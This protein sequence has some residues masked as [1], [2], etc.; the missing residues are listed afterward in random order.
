MGYSKRLEEIIKHNKDVSSLTKHY[1]DY[2]ILGAMHTVV[3]WTGDFHSCFYDS[4]SIQA[5]AIDFDY[6][7]I[8]VIDIDKKRIEMEVVCNHLE[9]HC[10]SYLFGVLNSINEKL[11]HGKCYVFG[12]KVV[13]SMSENYSGIT[14]YED[15]SRFSQNVYEDVKDSIRV[16]SE[17]FNQESVQLWQ[18]R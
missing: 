15:M 16:I 8:C 10:K 9:I 17:S 7:Y 14:V 6:E 11:V 3:D 18:I 12:D 4:L 1:R 13:Y 2:E 5:K